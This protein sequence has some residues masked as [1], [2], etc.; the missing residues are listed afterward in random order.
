MP[1][2][3]CSMAVA[4]R[5]RRSDLTL[6]R[7]RNPWQQGRMAQPRILI[8]QQLSAGATIALDEGQ[9]RHLGAALRL[10]A[11]DHVRAFN[12]RD[13]EW[14][15]T[16]ADVSKRGMNAHVEDFIRPARTTPD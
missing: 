16:I 6:A 11:G 10:V 4:E 12:A 3:E 8:D 14:R 13:G 7:A 15:A 2:V 9:A 5:R 1:S